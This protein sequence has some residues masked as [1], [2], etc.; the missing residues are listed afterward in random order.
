MIRDV[1]RFGDARAGAVAGAEKTAPP[2]VRFA[3]T[4]YRERTSRFPAPRV[5]RRRVLWT[6]P[7]DLGEMKSF[8]STLLR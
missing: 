1:E 8:V 3:K 4:A 2:S 5:A 6:D 7:A